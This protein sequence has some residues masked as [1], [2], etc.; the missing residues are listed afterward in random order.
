MYSFNESKYTS[1]LWESF[2]YK[3]HYNEYDYVS[4]F[5]IDRRQKEIDLELCD[6]RR[7]EAKYWEEK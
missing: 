4:R 3:L 5:F 7:E 6:M 1:L 2:R